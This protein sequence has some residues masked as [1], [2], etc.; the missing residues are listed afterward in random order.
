MLVTPMNRATFFVR[1]QEESLKLYRDI[2]GMR[3]YFHN[4]WDNDGINAV[5]NTTGE[6]LRA[7]V[8]EGSSDNVFG[9]LGIY[10]LSAASVA[11]APPPSR[12]ITTDVGDSAIVFTV[13]DVMSLYETIKAAGY[14]IMS[15]P[16]ALAQNPAYE[17]QGLEMQFRDPDGLIVNL[18]QP[19]VPKKMD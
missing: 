18:C 17:V 19:G 4:F 11:K 10:Q 8:L 3:I 12:S 7:I 9:K 14:L 6:S 1:D 2:L 16:A 5:M 15:A 13:K